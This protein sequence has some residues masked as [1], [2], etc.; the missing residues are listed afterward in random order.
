MKKEKKKNNDVKHNK[1]IIDLTSF[2]TPDDV[3]AD[4]NGSYTGT[5]AQTYFGGKPE[6]PVQDA[7][8]L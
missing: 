8:D 1:E 6:T 3:F 5:T 2:I 7:D 4:T